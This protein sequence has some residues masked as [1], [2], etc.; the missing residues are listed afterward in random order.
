MKKYYRIAG[1]E[2]E[3]NLPD[4][5]VYKEEWNLAPFSVQSVKQPHRYNYVSA[6]VLAPPTGE[7]LYIGD[8]F[9][10]YGDET[11]SIRFIGTVSRHM[12]DAYIRAEHRGYEHNI[13][14]KSAMF[15][16]EIGARTVLKSMDLEHL[17]TQHRGVILH[18]SYIEYR[19]K[20][21]LFTAPSETGKSTQ[22]DLWN[23]HCNAEIING[24][25]A[26]IC[27]RQ[28]QM[29][30]DSVPFSGGSGICKNRLLPLAAIVYLGKSEISE[31]KRLTGTQSFCKIWEGC[32][33]NSWNKEDMNIASEVVSSIAENVPVF[34]LQCR[35]DISAVKVLHDQLEME[36]II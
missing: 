33:V 25:R 29:Y 23:K 17:I 14:V 22:A 34:Y 26:C 7:L 35:P 13:Q 28:E 15:N 5:K 20:A 19:G 9:H 16:T 30:V 36:N 2:F 10:I 21:I 32:T 24:D 12:S 31:I 3:L 4:D 8:S 18:S 1:I 11:G 27:V 6:D